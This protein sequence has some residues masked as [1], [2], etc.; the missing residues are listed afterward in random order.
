MR[1][2]IQDLRYG[3]RMLR[4]DPGFTAIAILTLAL[5]IGAN[6]TIFSWI[7]ST[8]L[9]PLPGVSKTSDLYALTSGGTA[10]SPHVFSYPDFVDLRNRTQSFS[11]MLA[12][13]IYPMDLTGDG[14]PERTWGTLVSANYFDVL[15]VRPILGRGFLPAEDEK[16]GGAPVVV[17]SY[18]L[19][20]LRLG[21]NPRVVG[22]Q[23]NIDRHPYTII[24]VAPALFQGNQTGLRSEL[25][26]PISMEAQLVTDGGRLQRRDR[27]WLLVMGRV[28]DG[29]RP[30]QAR[31]ELDLL[32]QQ[33]VR[34]FPD[35]HQAGVHVGIYPL[36]RSPAGA[37]AYFYL[38]LPMLMAIAGVVLL[39]ACANV[40]NLLLVRSVSRRREI[41]IRLSL[42]AS[43]GR[44]VR[45]L[46]LESLMVAIAGG[47]LAMVI[48]LWTASLFVRFIP[49]AGIP[50]GLD[51][52]ADR[53]VLGMTLALS[54][55]TAIIFGVLPAVRA[56]G[57][58]PVTVLKEESG[59]ASGGI[60][61]ARLS[62]VL[63]VAQLS[64]SLLLLI[65]A[66][67]IVRGFREAQRFD[68]GFKSDHVLLAT[69]NL[70]SSGYNDQQGLE[71]QRQL[72]T[73][74]EN[75]P[76][77]KSVALAG[78]I[79]MG[80]GLSETSVLPEGYVAQPHEDMA[81]EDAEVSP[82]YFR[83][84]EISLIGG[85]DFALADQ[86][87]SQKVIIVNRAFADRYWPGQ[88]A[89]GK[90]VQASGVWR[91]V[92]GI[93]QTSNYDDLNE[94]PKPFVYL[95]L[96]QS[97]SS[98]AALHVRTYG[99]PLMAA[100]AV[101]KTAHAL[102]PDL[103]LYDVTTL[104]ARVEIAT[105]GERIAGTFVGAF[106]VL[107]LILGAVG[108]YGVVAYITRQRTHEIGIRLALGAQRSQVIRL[109]LIH[110]LRLT[111]AG[112]AIGLALSL[113]LTRFIA[114][115][116]FDV[117]PTDPLTFAVVCLLLSSVAVAACVI[118]ARRAMHVDPMVALRH[119]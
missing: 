16:P 46:F 54:V 1:N 4:K 5:G 101:E 45:Q 80:F 38:L 103:A 73:R 117:S 15:N 13:S 41:A 49:P 17:I 43:R 37:N 111:S 25:W 3:L 53:T 58:A 52:H 94:A 2:L 39:L 107:A 100:S 20:Q 78:W 8:L 31:Q 19:W 97:Y 22:T 9:N 98:L 95:P 29:V 77:V 6:S 32:L 21:G 26:V 104:A 106:G 105:T 12:S 7:N 114:P 60:R 69:F 44:L 91:T 74:L 76:G 48:T 96:F 50:I 24:G 30:E 14:N 55:L 82:G 85:R 27:N 40:A 33:L 116:M 108:I 102:L 119:E 89:I 57:I 88:Y 47:G 42:G 79:P 90:R 65:C 99:D 23:L 109:V 35:A 59:S 86:P 87:E 68:P 110:G 93:A 51:V 63:V 70:F 83:T 84:M 75:L 10:E 81:V 62:T 36:W 18:R 64:L 56:S 92:V 11:G 71:F 34:Q 118:P 28:R 72:Q 113:I 112:L 61:K 66:G 115:L 67:L